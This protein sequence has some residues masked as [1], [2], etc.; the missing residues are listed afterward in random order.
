[1][2]S[3]VPCTINSSVVSGPNIRLKDK[4]VS[5]EEARMRIRACQHEVGHEI[6]KNSYKNKEKTPNSVK[7]ISGIGVLVTVIAIL[8][9]K[10]KK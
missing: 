5:K 2:T 10:I 1:M 9:N 6:K 7:V 3:L 8:K 4:T